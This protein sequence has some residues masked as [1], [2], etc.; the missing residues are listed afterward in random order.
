MWHSPSIPTARRV[1]GLWIEQA[2]GT[3]AILPSIKAIY[4][5]ENGD[6]ALVRVEFEAEWGKRCPA[7]GQAWRRAWEHVV[8][9]FAFASG[10]HKMIYTTNAVE[11][12][13]RPLRKIIKRGAASNDAAALK[14]LYLATLASQA[15]IGLT[16]MPVLI[17]ALCLENAHRTGWQ[18]G[19]WRPS[20]ARR[21]AGWSQAVHLCMVASDM[22]KAV[23]PCRRPTI[24][25]RRLLAAAN[26]LLS[27]FRTLW[28][29]TIVLTISAQI[30]ARISP[31]ACWLA[32]GVNA[33]K[34]AVTANVK[35]LAT[36]ERETTAN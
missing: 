17:I 23:G 14:L 33:N 11:V 4:R 31:A 28:M 5:A 9:F 1:F 25:M 15:M 30:K 7:I 26:I 10:I 22:V 21:V 16:K 32:N 3:K 19:P 12:L 35:E 24:P 27:N 20:I 6:M 8:L 34:V 18:T 13:H 29:R 2:E 36:I